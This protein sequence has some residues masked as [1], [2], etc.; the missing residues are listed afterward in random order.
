M[1]KGIIKKTQN[2]IKKRQHLFNSLV[3][4]ISLKLTSI[5]KRLDYYN[6]KEPMQ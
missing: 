4:V 1:N 2:F 3:C 6:R 5:L